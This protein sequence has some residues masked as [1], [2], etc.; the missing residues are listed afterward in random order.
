MLLSLG[1]GE[2]RAKIGYLKQITGKHYDV[3]INLSKVHV[4]SFTFWTEAN[5]HKHGYDFQCWLLL[6]H[7]P[8]FW[9]RL[10]QSCTQVTTIPSAWNDFP[11]FP[12]ECLEYISLLKSISC[13]SNVGKYLNWLFF[14]GLPDLTY[15][16]F[17]YRVCNFREITFLDSTSI[18]INWEQ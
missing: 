18:Y 10:I 7:L 2:P 16:W 1:L 9:V 12:S 14:S 6:V 15:S 11:S 13:Y 3:Y 4:C 5:N 17:T 8:F